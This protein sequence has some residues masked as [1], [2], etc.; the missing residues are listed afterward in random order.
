MHYYKSSFPFG[1]DLSLIL[2]DR[3]EVEDVLTGPGHEHR[4]E[5]VAEDFGS[6]WRDE[7]ESGA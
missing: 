6:L 1:R 2:N 7:G 3:D 4:A 5:D